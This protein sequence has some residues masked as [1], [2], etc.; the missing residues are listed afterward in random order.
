MGS[1]LALLAVEK[2]KKTE[3]MMRRVLP[4]LTIENTQKTQ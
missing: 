1:G 2:K 3:N 4:L